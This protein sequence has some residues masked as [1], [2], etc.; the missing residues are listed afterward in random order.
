MSYLNVKTSYVY[1]CIGQ[2]VK[3]VDFS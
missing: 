2:V 3:D 1:L